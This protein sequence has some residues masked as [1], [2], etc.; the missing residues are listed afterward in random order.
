MNSPAQNQPHLLD[1]LTR[2]GVL[3]SV[4]VRY[5]RGRKKLT[6]EDLGLDARQVSERLISLGHKRILPKEA[7]Q[8]F[9]L[10]ESRVHSLIEA[11]TF[12]FLGG[13]ARFLPNA[14]LAEVRR[15]LEE[16]EADFARAVDGFLGGY[17]RRQSEAIAEWRRFAGRVGSDPDQVAA[18]VESAFP[19]AENVRGTFGFEVRLFQVALPEALRAET[20]ALGEQAAVVE[21]RRQAAAEAARKV[22]DD[23][24][25]FVS[26]CVAT[27][28]EQTAEICREMLESIK[29]GK[30]AGV[31]QKT[32]NRLLRFIDEFKTLNFAGDSE[33]EEHLERA[34]REL[35]S[36]TAEEYRDSAYSRRRLVNG[37]KELK[38]TATELAK[39]DA[40]A[41][42][43]RFG[44]MGRRKFHFAA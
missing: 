39:A 32:L 35:L 3:V 40:A 29:V 36:R 37:L 27:L 24:E 25:S 44:E 22:R 38:E 12:P 30:T 5:W 23:A 18:A 33:L 20:V 2:E 26:D 4:S 28:R 8:S 15:K 43:E 13:I 19:T 31:H 11:S 6:P 10:T 17:S 1:V 14:K 34:K 41:V 16:Y 9:A 42:V 7:F 21:A